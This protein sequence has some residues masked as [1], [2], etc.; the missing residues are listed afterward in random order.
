MTGLFCTLINFHTHTH[1]HTHTLSLSQGSGDVKYHLGTCIE[2]VNTA[3]NKDVKIS[4]VANPSHLEGTCMTIAELY[5][6]NVHV[7]VHVHL[8]TCTVHVLK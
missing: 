8:C 6:S 3:T 2:R 7:H 1:T 5:Y 4:I